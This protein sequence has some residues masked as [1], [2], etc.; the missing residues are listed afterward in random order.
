MP[1]PGVGNRF[2]TLSSWVN[3]YTSREC[4]RG[5]VHTNGIENF[6]SLLKRGLGGTYLVGKQLIAGRS[7]QDEAA[8]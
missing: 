5:L 4:V 6:W 2:T 1:T 3:A 7:P 8:D